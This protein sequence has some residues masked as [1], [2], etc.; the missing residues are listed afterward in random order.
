MSD[1]W[2]DVRTWFE[3]ALDHPVAEREAFVKSHCGADPALVDEVVGLL[4]AAERESTFGAALESGP[5]R[6]P[7]ALAPGDRV[8]RYRLERVLGHGGM[9]TVWAARQDA[10]DRLVALKVLQHALARPEDVARFRFEAEVLAR[11]RH[12]NIAQ[13][14][15]AGQLVGGQPFFALE[16]VDGGTPL[17]AH[18]KARALPRRERL[19]LLATI[20]DA[21]AHGHQRGVV[22]RDLKSANVLVDSAGFPKVIDFGIARAID[23]G[24]V[25]APSFTRTGEVVGT[26]SSMAPEQ[27]VTAADAVDVRTDVYQLGVMLYQLLT[28]RLPIDLAG[29]SI[30]DA[31]RR[32]ETED[33]KPPSSWV[34]DVPRELDWIAAR[35]LAKD[36]ERRYASAS[37]FAADLRRHLAGDAVLAAPDGLSYRIAVFTRRH[38][39][40]LVATAVAM[41]GLIVGLVAALRARGREFEARVRVESAL[42]RAR[43]ANAFMVGMLS[44]VRP[45]ESGRDVR[46][47]DVL[48]VADLDLARGF[49]G[50]PEVETAARATLGASWLALDVVES[51]QPHLVAAYELRERTLGPDDPETLDSLRDLATLRS[52]QGRAREA[53]QLFE[54]L[55]ARGTRVLGADHP[56]PW[57]ARA[58][59]A[60]VMHSCGDLVAAE[61]E[62]RAAKD[63]FARLVPA[64]DIRRS[65]A[66]Q[67]LTSILEARGD[68]E[69]AIELARASYERLQ[70]ALGPTHPRT[71]SAANQ[72]GRLSI[73]GGRVDEGVALLESALNAAAERLGADHDLTLRVEESLITSLRNTARADEAARRF[74]DVIAR[75]TRKDGARHARTLQVRGMF[76][77]T[78]ARLG[79]LEQAVAEIDE[80]HALAVTALG[81]DDPITLQLATWLAQT[82]LD[83]G[84]VQGAEADLRRVLDSPEASQ[85]ATAPRML[86]IKET[87]ALVLRDSGRAADGAPLMR[88]V[89]DARRRALGDGALDTLRAFLHASGLEAMTG[90]LELATQYA[91]SAHDGFRAIYGRDH[92]A[93]LVSTQTLA[94]I[95]GRRGEWAAA[96]P[97]QQNALELA[98]HL[99]G[100]DHPAV[101][102]AEGELGMSLRR[103]D[104]SAEARALLDGARKSRERVFGRDNPWCRS[105][106]AEYAA[107][108]LD[109]GDVVG[110]ATALDALAED[111]DELA[112][113]ANAWTAVPRANPPGFTFGP[114][115]DSTSRFGARLAAVLA[116]SESPMLGQALREAVL[117]HASATAAPLET[118]AE[119]EALASP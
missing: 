68:D 86:A 28:D 115:V 13:I 27:L 9:G 97:L 21:V 56:D 17:H 26:L 117:A 77:T 96:E 101:H 36:K 114:T 88:D 102:D 50:P 111:L 34:R 10:P 103:L 71:L 39:I 18:V 113:V 31:A 118:I 5:L 70:S 57:L 1:R 4:R 3:R 29:A 119:L 65:E 33:P 20:C 25:E 109:L 23:V 62:A 30:V 55:V 82:R 84:D 41:L 75:R 16:Y 47:R 64:A 44:A 107:A 51:A 67:A 63:A 43:S 69:G 106:R 22:H 83:S 74:V 15:E 14:H 104:R 110:A 108:C 54:E 116:N 24:A 49:D 90:D 8:G 94:T 66:E 112:A 7:A 73:D 100:A 81:A 76:G 52:R 2:Q 60:I 19:A 87:L 72:L 11:L 48:S 89:L 80:A 79:R 37:E 95:L 78:L 42:R 32:I 98:T 45:D 85:H 105:A 93:V 59:L 46:V 40:G 99:Y 92:V 61:R 12:P 38:R 58:H 91:R 35:A 53:R 6:A